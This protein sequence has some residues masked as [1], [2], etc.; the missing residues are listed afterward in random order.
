MAHSGLGEDGEPAAGEDGAGA[1][2]T[3]AAK[4]K[5]HFPDHRPLSEIQAGLKAGRLHQGTLRVSRFNPLEG[6][7]SSLRLCCSYL[8]Q[9]LAMRTMA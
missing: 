6:T 5:R 4:R 7:F 9:F 2:P 3:K 8:L 1:G